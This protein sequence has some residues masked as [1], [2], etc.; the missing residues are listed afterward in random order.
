VIYILFNIFAPL[1][2]PGYNTAGDLTPVGT[3]TRRLWAWLAAPYFILSI[4]F[5]AAIWKRS[6][7]NPP[8][9]IAAV[10]M[11]MYGVVCTIWLFAP[12]LQSKTITVV[13][14]DFLDTLYF[15]LG[16]TSQ[17]IYLLA[18]GFTAAAFGKWFRRYAIA[19][20]IAL[21]IFGALVFIVVPVIS[22]ST[23]T[24]PY[25]IWERIN[26]CILLLW[27]MVLTLTCYGNKSRSGS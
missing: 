4:V 26:I 10:L 18:L 11:I 23:P 20:F 6:G 2:W 12:I 21:L 27:I 13:K 3:P 17:I 24:P 8:L 19:I 15:S 25:G 1:H 9:R 16:L 22:P 5:T 7:Q 14:G